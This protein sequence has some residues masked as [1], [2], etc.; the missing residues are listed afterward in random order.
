MRKNKAMKKMKKKKNRISR[1]RVVKLDNPGAKSDIC[2]LQMDLARGAKLEID[3]EAG[4]IRNASLITKG[5]ALG[6]GF[7]IDDIMLKQVVSKTSSKGIK[8][9]LTHPDGGWFGGK[10]GVEVLLGTVKNPRVDGDQVRC[11]IHFGKYAEKI[12]GLGNVKDYLL[13]LAESNPE[14]LG[15]SIVFDRSPFTERTENGLPL[16]PAGRV[17]RVLAADFVGDPAANPKGMLAAGDNDESDASDDDAKNNPDIGDIEMDK[18]LRAYLKKLGIVTDKMSDAEA[19]TAFKALNAEMQKTVTALAES[20]SLDDDAK[21]ADPPVEPQPLAAGGGD[22]APGALGND[23]LSQ[24]QMLAE[25]NRI[26][27]LSIIAASAG[28]DVNWL[29]KCINEKTSLADARALAIKLTEGKRP[30]IVGLGTHTH[31][32][33][34]GDNRRDALGDAIVDAVLLKSGSGSALQVVTDD[35][36]GLAVID[37]DR[38]VHELAREFRGMNLVEMGRKFLNEMGYDAQHLSKAE[39]A[40]K[41]FEVKVQLT[42]GTSDFPSLLMDASNKTLR[43]AYLEAPSVWPNICGRDTAPDFKTINMVA[44]GEVPDLSLVNEFGEYP[45]VKIGEAKETC[46]LAKYGN[47]IALSWE[48][49]INDDTKA[50]VNTTV[51]MGQAARRKEDALAINV[52]TTNGNMADSNPLFSAAHGNIAS[53]G[54]APSINTLNAMELAIGTQTGISADVTLDYNPALLL[55]PRALKGTISTL[56]TSLYNPANG[57]MEANIWHKKL[58][59]HY[60]ARLDNVSTTGWYGF[61]DPAILAT[62]IMYFLEGEE[63]PNI[64]VSEE[65]NDMRIYQIRH[66]IACGANDYRGAWYNAGA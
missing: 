15:L 35:T 25:S 37:K 36:T 6:H 18:K 32:D 33:V 47:R 65:K 8:C 49:L 5:D 20:E 4:V 21:P 39:V 60:T 45:L 34:T 24:A 13:D 7:V 11:D 19:L 16:K 3:R 64:T 57:N 1:N 50:F 23:A 9:R 30:G 54:A 12:P 26:S 48:T 44:G 52:L 61:V 40:R 17:K 41:L 62:L 29:A 55:A 2:M 31:I 10:D 56:L 58:T 38:K 66:V 27:G 28:L 59:D 53:S 14:Y 42:Q 63:Q 46:K 51:K 22:P 43:A